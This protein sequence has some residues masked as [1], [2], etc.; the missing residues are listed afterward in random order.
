MDRIKKIFS[1]KAKVFVAYITAGFPSVDDTLKLMN[2]L[3]DN[4]VDIIELGYPFSDPAADGPS[5]Q[6][7]SQIALD[8][9]FKRDHY[10]EILRKFRVNNDTNPVVVFGYLNPVYNMGIKPFVANVKE[11]GGDALLIVD[12]PFEEQSE[13]RPDADS[14][15]L[16]IIQLVSPS[17][18]SD[19]MKSILESATGFVYQI[20]I[21][22]VTGE[23]ENIEETVTK[24]TRE[25]KSQTDLPIALGFGISKAAQIESVIETVDGI[26]IGSSIINTIRDNMKNYEAPLIKKIRELSESIHHAN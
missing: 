8:K 15:G 25:I 11:S 21:R 3:V 22:G 24:H 9:G 13:I 20:S 4:G 7:S 10:F 5:I 2:I 1:E 19:R 26:V 14:C 12:L 6:I 17:T 23:R 16:H 18:N